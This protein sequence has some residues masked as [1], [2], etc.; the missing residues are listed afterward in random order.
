[1][2]LAE[3]QKFGSHVMKTIKRRNRNHIGSDA[4]YEGH[5]AL[6]IA[7]DHIPISN[8]AYEDSE[9]DSETLLI[10]ST[11]FIRATSILYMLVRR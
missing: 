6:Q 1:M 9:G 7:K 2:L 8:S 3:G 5:E 10:G 11:K 4:E